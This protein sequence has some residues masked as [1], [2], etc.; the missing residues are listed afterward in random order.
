MAGLQQGN[1]RSAAGK[2]PIRS[3]QPL[4]FK[5]TRHPQIQALRYRDINGL[6]S[7]L[8]FIGDWGFVIQSAFPENLYVMPE[9]YG[10][11]PPWNGLY[12]VL[13]MI[14]CGGGRMYY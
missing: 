12:I 3:R 9:V 1:G 7:P 8:T 10:C 4:S 5:K 2:W 13:N 11:L 6:P 14:I